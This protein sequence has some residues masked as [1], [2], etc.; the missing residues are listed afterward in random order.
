MHARRRSMVN[1]IKAKK[2]RKRR[3]QAKKAQS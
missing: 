1:H 2:L 3:K